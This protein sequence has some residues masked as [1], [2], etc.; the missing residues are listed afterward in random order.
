MTVFTGQTPDDVTVDLTNAEPDVGPMEDLTVDELLA[1]LPQAAAICDAD[2][3][4]RETNARWATFIMETTGRGER[5]GPGL[6]YLEECER[7]RGAPGEWSAAAAVA[8]RSVSSGAE[9]VATIEYSW[10]VDDQERWYRLQYSALPG[11]ELR[12]GVL[13]SIHD[14]TADRQITER[15]THL[16]HH[17]PLTGLPNRNLFYELY[18]Q[19]IA[20]SDRHDER[21]FV[22]FCDLDRFKIVNERFGHQMG[23]EL[24]RAVASRLKASLR[25]SDVVARYGGDEFLVLL[26]DVIEPEVAEHVARRLIADVSRPFRLHGER[27]EV[28]LSIGMTEASPSQ[29]TE[30]V[31]RTAN[32]AMFQAKAAG[33]SC[34][35]M[36][37]EDQLFAARAGLR[38]R[39]DLTE[40]EEEHL[41]TH[42]QP[43]I[44]LTDGSVVGVEALLRWSHPQYGIIPAGE[45]LGLAINSG[46]INQLSDQALTAAT[47][48]WIDIRDELTGPPPQLFLNLS[49]DQLTSRS[50]VERLHHLLVSTGLPPEELVLE[51]TEEAMT[52]KTSDV[53]ERLGQLRELGIR[54]A[55]DDFGSGY[56]SLGRLRHLPVQVLKID[57]SLIRGVEVDRRARQLL[58]SIGSMA[59]ELEV[60]CIVEGCETAEEAA[61]LVDLGFRF[62]QG[63][64]F[65]RPM[66][67]D[68][69]IPFLNNR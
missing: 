13:L 30:D 58:A 64:H 47:D 66:P 16:A 32:D 62:A 55:V 40:I 10:Q 21:V 65:A 3:V 4:V 60:S 45:F 28:G 8:F 49:P 31:I 54:L 41:C 17:D 26:P 39:L 33:R 19:A 52:A 57:Q 7:G 53:S 51:I 22:M 15:L 42:F 61:V 67:A 48:T 24:L 34:T 38:G 43:I 29:D 59:V 46:L 2:G 1:A 56:S 6:N 35:V 37:N 27:L 25:P 12:R 5:C 20:L 36:A 50:S 44:D 18:G 9:S 14:V 23:D 69:L 11:L 63:F 68:E